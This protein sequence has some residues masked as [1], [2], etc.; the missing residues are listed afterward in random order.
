MAILIKN[1]VAIKEGPVEELRGDLRAEKISVSHIKYTAEE[2]TAHG[3]KYPR[4]AA[5]SSKTVRK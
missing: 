3:E 2:C 1:G 4:P 5:H